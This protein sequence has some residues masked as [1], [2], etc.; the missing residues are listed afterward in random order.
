MKQILLCLLLFTGLVAMSY[1]GAYQP[2]KS[3][4]GAYPYVA[5]DACAPP[6]IAVGADR[7]D[8]AQVP[9]TI[10]LTIGGGTCDSVTGA[11]L[12][13]WMTLEKTGANMGRLILAPTDS[14]DATDY[15]FTAHGCSDALDT[16]NITVTW[17][18]VKL[19]SVDPDT[20]WWGDTANI[21]GRGFKNAQGTSTFAWG[22]STPTM[23]LWKNDTLKPICPQ[24]DTGFYTFIVSNG[25]M[26]DTL[27]T[28][29][30]YVAGYL[31][32]TY[33]LTL[34]A[35]NGSTVP[36]SGDT[37]VDSGSVITIAATPDAGY[38]F[39]HWTDTGSVV[40]NVD[41]TTAT[42][43][44]N[45]L[46]TAVFAVKQFTLIM[47]ANVHSTTI[48]PNGDTL[49]DSGGVVTISCTPDAGY[50]FTGW[51]VVSG[52]LDLGVDSTTV[53]VN[54]DGTLKAVLVKFEI[55]EQ[56]KDTAIMAGD[57]FNI[58]VSATGLNLT[59]KWQRQ[60]CTCSSG[61][62]LCGE[63]VDFDGETDS[64]ISITAADSMNYDSVR[65]IV[66]DDSYS[67]TSNSAYISIISNITIDADTTIYCKLVS[68]SALIETD[69][70]S[71]TLAEGIT[72]TVA[73]MSGIGGT[74]EAPDTI[75]GAGAGA[76]YTGPQDTLSNT[77]VALLTCTNPLYLDSSAN[78]SGNNTNVKSLSYTGATLSSATGLA[79]DT[80]GISTG[81]GLVGGAA[82][83]GDSAVT[84]TVV[85]SDSGYI[86]VP[87]AMPVGTYDVG[88]S[89]SDGDTLTLVGGLEVMASGGLKNIIRRF[90]FKFGF[91]F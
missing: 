68:D 41:S 35:T 80:I 31:Y 17:G 14:V 67:D 83:I 71:I 27:T 76:T 23:A 54:G 1:K 45:V 73:V 72:W 30:I 66:A 10:T 62:L 28:D 86:V 52:E 29:S 82:S 78:T 36:A 6:T 57:A 79:G 50:T 69:G 90:A 3:Y 85:N 56:P 2:D 12:P 77:R 40:Y 18:D 5:S 89:N 49:V 63:W 4:K 26:S 22:D 19:T 70:I 91:R 39:S 60:I 58:F 11:S 55:T 21:L 75:Q 81:N 37:T 20:V 7:I 74:T 51:E 13:A 38:T 65:C 33:T 34:A 88:L 43:N 32:P 25:T 46:L 16:V 64:I 24:M 84:L 59:Y 8:T 61:G 44:G 47:N 48:P 87:L 9:D 53:T 15:I 42:I